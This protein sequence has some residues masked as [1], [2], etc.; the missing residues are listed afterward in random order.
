MELECPICYEI[1]E[2][3]NSVVTECGHK[4]HT[5]CLMANVAH[6]GFSCPCCR[7]TMAEIPEE[8]KDEEEDDWESEDEGNEINDYALRGMRWLYQRANGEDLDDEEDEPGEEDEEEITP[9]PSVEL[10]TRKLKQQGITMEELVKTLLLQHEEY[11][12]EEEEYD[13]V[14]NELFGKIR[15]IVSNYNVAEDTTPKVEISKKTEISVDR[16]YENRFLTVV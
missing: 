13:Q 8:E 14:D 16:F 7:S 1:I 4:F 12:R 6:N 5:K 3:T 11:A 15:I 10:I 2:N 9:K